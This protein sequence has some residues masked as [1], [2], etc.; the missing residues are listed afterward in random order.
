LGGSRDMSNLHVVYFEREGVHSQAVTLMMQ[1][2]NIRVTRITSE[3]EIPDTFEIPPTQCIVSLDHFASLNKVLSLL[4][5]V[6]PAHVPYCVASGVNQLM[7]FKVTPMGIPLITIKPDFSATLLPKPI[8]LDKLSR[9]L[10]AED[11]PRELLAVTSYSGLKVLI[12]EDNPMNQKIAIRMLQNLNCKV[13]VA[14]NGLQAIDCVEKNPD[15]HV[16]FMDLHMVGGVSGAV[17][18]GLARNGRV[19]CDQEN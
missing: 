2:M 18:M 17:I 1:E 19:E 15:I 3:N 11:S 9:F 8:R 12:T 16:I 4:R 7:D 5:G 14:M 13:L 10:T 6:I